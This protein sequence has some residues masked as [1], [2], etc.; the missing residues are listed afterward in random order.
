MC[1]VTWVKV[2]DFGNHDKMT[3]RSVCVAILFYCIAE[4]RPNWDMQ[5]TSMQSRWMYTKIFI[6]VNCELVN[7]IVFFIL[8]H[9]I[10][11][12]LVVSIIISY[13]LS[14]SSYINLCM[15]EYNV[16]YLCGFT[17]HILT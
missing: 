11:I 1:Q 4:C 15:I 6:L 3:R 9:D 5:S 7:L 13:M 8:L 10:A 16:I 14:D 12:I 17:H 2:E